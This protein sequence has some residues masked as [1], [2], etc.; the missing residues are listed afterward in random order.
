MLQRVL[1]EVSYAGA[2]ERKVGDRAATARLLATEGA[3]IAILDCNLPHAEAEVGRISEAGAKAAAWQCDVSDSGQVKAVIN[4]AV[5]KFGAPH[6]L[7]NN[8]GIAIRRTV[9]DSEPEDWD[10]IMEINVRGAFLCS[11]NSACL[12]S[13]PRAPALFIRRL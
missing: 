8:A 4:D 3:S 10:R 11:Q 9:G 13:A 6:V 7:F 12:I 1:D 2:P 5:P